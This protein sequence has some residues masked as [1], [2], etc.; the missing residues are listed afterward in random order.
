MSECVET[1]NR[2][3]KRMDDKTFDY[4]KRQ[5]WEDEIESS[6]NNYSFEKF[7]NDCC[8]VFRPNNQVGP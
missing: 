5:I 2:L 6:I 8:M 3:K 4:N 7:M 1:F